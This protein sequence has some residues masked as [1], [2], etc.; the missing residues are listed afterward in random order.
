MLFDDNRGTVTG[1]AFE[2]DKGGRAIEIGAN[3][4]AGEAGYARARRGAWFVDRSGTRH[5]GVV[6]N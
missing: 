5:T 6:E 3:D 4:L 1:F 2:V